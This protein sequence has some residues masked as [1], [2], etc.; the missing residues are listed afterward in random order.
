MV[1]VARPLRQ[2]AYFVAD[3]RQAAIDRLRRFGSGPSFVLDH[4]ALA[5]SEH[6]GVAWPLDHSSAY[7]Q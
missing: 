5:R 4:V 3:A 7:G 6:S 1:P 2:I